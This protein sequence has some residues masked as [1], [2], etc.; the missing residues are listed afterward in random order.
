MGDA[1]AATA[2]ELLERD[3]TDEAAGTLEADVIALPEHGI[4]RWE[5]EQPDPHNKGQIR[6]VVFVRITKAYLDAL[7]RKGEEHGRRIIEDGLTRLPADGGR[8]NSHFGLSPEAI[9]EMCDGP[10]PT[11]DDFVKRM[12][13]VEGNLRFKWQERVLASGER[14]IAS[15]KKLHVPRP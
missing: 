13:D 12:G 6:T 4:E 1:G 14:W 8:R 2:E 7:E 3:V 15:S 9:A 11:R 5:E 10:L